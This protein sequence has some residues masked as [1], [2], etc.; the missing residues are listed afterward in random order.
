M[1]VLGTIKV[2]VMVWV[3]ASLSSICAD[4]WA[5]FGVQFAGKMIEV[6]HEI[7]FDYNNRG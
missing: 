2:P 5:H 6:L 7:E 3:G 4:S 1:D